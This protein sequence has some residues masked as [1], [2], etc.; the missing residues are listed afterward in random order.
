D[1]NTVEL[2]DT[3]YYEKL[4]EF[5]DTEVDSDNIKTEK[6]MARP[7]EMP[8]EITLK[9]TNV[10]D[11]F[12]KKIE[13]YGPDLLAMSCTEDMFELG[14]LLLKQVRKYRIPTILGG[15]FATF[16]PNLA[17]SYNEI[18]IVCKGEGEDSL[19]SLCRRMRTGK[20]YD[21]IPNLWIKNKDGS[22]KTNPT[23]MV[24]MD[25]NPL[26]DMSIFEEARF[27]RPMG[28]KVYRMFP[29]ETFRGCPYKCSFCNSPSQ[30]TMYR[31]ETG[32]SYIRR[33]SFENMRKEL[34]FYKEEMGAQ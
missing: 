15:V 26:I 11:D 7:Y 1:G 19:R 9:T 24:N 5:G 28:G 20:R 21:D 29:V 23:K 13:F 27:Y 8:N 25:A 33:K 18:D 34:L 10:L 22:I 31:E 3:T 14:I 6:L 30:E 16:A 4:D 2:F 17:L 12:K 32:E